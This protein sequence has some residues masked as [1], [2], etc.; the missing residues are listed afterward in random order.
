MKIVVDAMGGDF[1]PLEIVKGA[2]KAAREYKVEIILVGKKPLLHV[3]AG[4]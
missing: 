3:L 1:A 4:K 2:I